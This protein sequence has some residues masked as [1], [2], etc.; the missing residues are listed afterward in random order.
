MKTFGGNSLGKK[1]ALHPKANI[2]FELNN[3]NHS[4]IIPQ[5]TK[6][7]NTAHHT[8]V[9]EI[10]K[11][12]RLFMVTMEAARSDQRAPLSPV[13]WAVGEGKKER[14]KEIIKLVTEKETEIL[15]A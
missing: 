9:M 14:K 3:H 10:P 2:Y 13:Q 11:R 15:K 7:T 8:P 5:T 4:T 12:A 6:T 1:H